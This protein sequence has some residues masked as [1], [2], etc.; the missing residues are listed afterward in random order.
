MGI[1]QLSKLIKEKCPKG[2]IPRKFN[3]YSSSKVAID[4]SL[5]IY[6]FLIAVRSD[7]SNLGFNDETT[8]HIIGLFYRT[9]KMVEAGL[10]PVFVFDGK[11]PAMKIAELQK[12]LEKREKA[13][14]MAEIAEMNNDKEEVAKQEKRKVKV[15]E[16]H[17]N[18]CKKLLKLMGIPFVTAISESEAYCSYLCKNKYVDGV[19][20][21]DM[22][23]LCFGTPILLRN[24]N[25]SQSK[26]L[27][28]DEYNL[29]IILKEM[30]I[31]MKQFTDLCILLGCDYCDTIKGIGYKR[32]YDFIKKHGSI[33]EILKNEK[34]E[35]PENFDYESAREIF[36]SLGNMGEPGTFKIDYDSVDVEG[37]VEYLC[38]EKGFDE[39]RV[40]NGVEKIMKTKTRG[41]QK[42]IS[43]FFCKG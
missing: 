19:A 12:R 34:T 29:S 30:D 8:S 28:I 35:V 23:A 16:T 33:E 31:D 3:Y 20:T 32:A 10:I 7:G 15:E 5:C 25:A 36:H 11:A 22:D 42:K 27:D 43:D 17:V 4:A 41:V 1:K 6:Q 39:K 18:D 40:K 9:I 2:V 26:K 13:T 37:L 24:M 21:E 38:T 14:K